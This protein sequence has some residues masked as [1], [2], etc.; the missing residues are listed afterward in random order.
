MPGMLEVAQATVTIVPTMLGAQKTIKKE[1]TDIGD[2]AASSA[3]DS[4]GKTFA[5]KMGSG[6]SKAGSVIGKAVKGFASF[7]GAVTAGTAALTAFASKT[8]D[9]LSEIG[10]MS[11]KTGLS[12][13]SYQEL[14]YAMRMNGADISSMTVG[15]KTLTNQITSAAEGNKSAAAAFEE[16]GISVTNADGSMR[17]QEEVMWEAMS[18]LQGVENSTQKAALASQLFGKAGT[19]LMVMLNGE[20]GSIDA[21]RKEAHDLGLVMGEDVVAQGHELGDQ[22][23]KTK[24]SFEAL[25]TQLGAAL[26]PVALELTD[27]VQSMMPDIQG[28]IQEITPVVQTL[29]QQLLPPIQNLISTLLPSIMKLVTA[30]LPILNPVLQILTPFINLISKIVGV[31]TTALMPIINI[32]TKALEGVSKAVQAVVGWF[33]KMDFKWPKIKLPHFSI[34]PQGWKIGDLLKGS[35]PKLGISWYAKAA[36]EGAEFRQPTVVGV[37]DAAQPEMLIGKNTLRAMIGDAVQGSTENNIT[38]N[39]Y[40]SAGMDEEALARRTVELI[41]QT[42]ERRRLAYA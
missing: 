6:L 31:L 15:M 12:T 16:L 39:V 20:A 25:T 27:F 14:A 37:G 2:D 21:L 4:A 26:L 22:M 38:V 3:G 28:L 33:S 9:S 1:L 18:A 8:A 10:D 17:S 41:Q 35:F 11:V 23:E 32:V 34:T 13:D 36:T 19:D 40:P 5:E 42:T 29:F 7:A 24:A 30:L